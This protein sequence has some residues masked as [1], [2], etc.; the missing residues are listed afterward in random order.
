MARTAGLFGRLEEHLAGPAD[1]ETRRKQKL[2]VVVVA[3]VGA[4]AT[5][6]NAVPLFAGGLDPM[7]W[8]YVASAQ[9]V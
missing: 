6:F 1:T 3:V 9:F 2:V 5:A 4:I 7:G 8:T